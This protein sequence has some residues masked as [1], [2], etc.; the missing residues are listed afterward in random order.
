MKKREYSLEFKLEVVKSYLE[1]ANGVRLVARYYKL[2]SKNYVTL[3]LKELNEKGLL[4]GYQDKIIEKSK[5]ADRVGTY[6]ENQKTAYEKELEKE[7]LRL[8]AENDFLKKLDEIERRN[9]KKK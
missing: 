2:P 6:S 5:V 3:W 9:A 8:K 7:V 4:E 1:G